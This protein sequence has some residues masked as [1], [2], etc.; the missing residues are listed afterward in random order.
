LAIS[1]KY[2]LRPQSLSVSWKSGS[3]VRGEQA[4]TTT[5]FSLFSFMI[6]Y[7]FSWLSCEHVKR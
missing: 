6:S 7:T 2:L 1:N 4:A 5:R 3:W